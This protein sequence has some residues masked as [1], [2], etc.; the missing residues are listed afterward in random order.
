MRKCGGGLKSREACLVGWSR[1]KRTDT[2]DLT[3]LLWPDCPKRRDEAE[4][5]ENSTG[6]TRQARTRSSGP[7]S[8]VATDGERARQMDTAWEQTMLLLA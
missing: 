3:M 5:G 1:S 8:A 4:R 2:D 6:E 7:R